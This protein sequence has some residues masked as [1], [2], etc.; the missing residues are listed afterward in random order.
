MPVHL[1]T[2]APHSST[3]SQEMTIIVKP[4]LKESVILYWLVL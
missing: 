3:S 4:N 2:V 1:K